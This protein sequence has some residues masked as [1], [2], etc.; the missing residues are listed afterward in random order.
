MDPQL[1]V[2]R[3][4]NAEFV[5]KL[6]RAC[7]V[8]ELSLRG[9]LAPPFIPLRFSFRGESHELLEIDSLEGPRALRETE[10]RFIEREWVLTP[11]SLASATV[12]AD[13]DL[14]WIRRLVK[15]GLKKGGTFQIG[16]PSK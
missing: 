3:V 7:Q 13:L 9:G 10:E 16:K 1:E 11:G 5:P 4:Q 6:K 8:V 15:R 14:P 12:R 2:V